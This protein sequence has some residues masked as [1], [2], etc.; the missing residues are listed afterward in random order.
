MANP[1]TST[2]PKEFVLCFDG[3]G[4]KFHG[5]VSD[6]N[7]LKIFRMLDRNDASHCHYYQPGIGTY[8]TSP[9]LTDKGRLEK[10]KS[11]YMKAKDSAIGST[12][13]EHVMG[14]YKFLM[15]YYS[16]GDK[17]Y[18]FGF[19]RGAYVARFL[20]E[21]LDYIGLLEK[22]NEELVRFAWK[23]FSKWQR[24]GRDKKHNNDEF[25]FMAAFR[26]TF[27]RPITQIEFLGL[28]DTVNSVPRFENPWMQRSRFPYTARTSAK[29]IRHAVSIDE[30]RAKFRQ[31]LI[32]EVKP[33]EGHQHSWLHQHLKKHD[34]YLKRHHIMHK[35]QGADTKTSDES[36][37]QASTIY[38]PTQRM[39]RTNKGKP[40]PI[41][42]QADSSAVAAGASS[43]E[44]QSDYSWQSAGSLLESGIGEAK[45]T[46]NHGDYEYVEDA[47]QD[48]EEVWFPGGHADIGGG[49]AL[50]NGEHWALSHAPLVWMVQEAQRAGL[51]FNR[52]KMEQFDCWDESFESDLSAHA[53]QEKRGN[54]ETGSECEA[55]SK[56][57]EVDESGFCQALR[58]S[59]TD[60]KLHDCLSIGKGV[61]T[62]S[63]LS[64]KIMEYMP[65]RRMDLQPDGSWKPIRWP[66]PCG[67]VRDI[68]ADAQ[69]HVSAIRRMQANPDY[70]PGNLIIGGGGRGVKKAAAKYGIGE[71][72]I[73]KYSGSPVR[74]TYIRKN[75]G[76][77]TA[78]AVSVH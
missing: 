30:R 74:E 41:R 56:E 73:F 28:F 44:S 58:S 51:V 75:N 4:N 7:V 60:G 71:W 6:S 68:P 67:E 53:V 27:S 36:G 59:S 43:K 8:V 76:G 48:I 19:S 45:T 61:P 2:G 46:S 49:W 64:W 35:G 39:R 42:R 69:I 54:Q 38:R 23:T 40:Q 11:A 63:V 52:G 25:K 47:P 13:A 34:L 5:G 26:D 37:Q 10:I 3:T 57:G 17:L 20:A 50:D 15:R 33:T 31:D 77:N 65:F 70:R 12:F 29:F 66:L 55:S 32:S 1:E 16:P 14:G 72:D 18:F 9:S 62:S 21:M 78:G 24:R 22:G